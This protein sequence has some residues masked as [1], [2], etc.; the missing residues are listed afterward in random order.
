VY[1]MVTPLKYCR[2]TT[3]QDSSP[4][5]RCTGK[6]QPLDAGQ[7]INLKPSCRTIRYRLLYANRSLRANPG[8][9]DNSE[10]HRG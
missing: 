8:T 3:C 7:P 2:I 10:R 6:K 1:S 5:Y 4:E 9:S